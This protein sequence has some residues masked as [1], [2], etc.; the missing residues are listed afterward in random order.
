ML[1]ETYTDEAVIKQVNES[2]IP[3]VLDADEHERLVRAIG[4]SVFR[5]R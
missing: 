3:V 5:R 1:G 2:F 4:I